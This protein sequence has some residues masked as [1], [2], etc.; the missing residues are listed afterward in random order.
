MTMTKTKA[1]SLLRQYSRSIFALINYSHYTA[2]SC[3]MNV[4]VT[5]TREAV[6][7]QYALKEEKRK[8]KVARRAR[9]YRANHESETTRQRRLK[10][11]RERQ[12]RIRE[13]HR[14][15]RAEAAQKARQEKLLPPNLIQSH[16]PAPFIHGFI[17]PTFYSYALGGVYSTGHH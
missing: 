4:P 10:R 11:N 5:L 15:R 14:K 1:R 12:R 17:T 2:V 8:E 6:L 3:N 16:L 13:Q 9:E 7:N